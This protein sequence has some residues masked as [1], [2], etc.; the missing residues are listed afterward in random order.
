L[1]AI[2]GLQAVPLPGA[3]Q[4]A[5]NGELR[6][7]WAEAL[8]LVGTPDAW[9]PLTLE[10]AATRREVLKWLL[11]AAVW[12]VAVRLGQRRGT[13][14]ATQFVFGLGVVLGLTTWA[15]W[16]LGATQVFGVYQPV[17]ATGR[18]P[19]P[20]LN[21]NNL[22]C[23]LNLAAFCG[24]GLVTSRRSTR[25]E[26][27]LGLV[28]T[29][30]LAAGSILSGSRAGAGGLA[31]GFLAYGVVTLYR[32]RSVRF[33]LSVAWPSVAVVGLGLALAGLAMTRRA[34]NELQDASLVKFLPMDWALR[35]IWD[36]PFTG[37]GRGAFGAAVGPYRDQ[38]GAHTV[39]E[40]P[41]NWVLEWISGWGIPVGLLAVGTLLGA[42]APRRLL[43]GSWRSRLPLYIGCVVFVCQ[44]LVDL[45]S[46]VPG[47][48][49]PWLLLFGVLWGSRSARGAASAAKARVVGHQVW[50]LW[51]FCGL[52]LVLSAWFAAMPLALA[53]DERRQ[54]SSR[55][56][57]PQLYERAR[58]AVRAHPGDPYLL[59]V[60]ALSAHQARSPLALKWVNAALRRDPNN[61]RTL[62][63]LAQILQER[64]AVG[65]ALVS[66][67][68]AASQEQALA[69]TVAQIV[70]GWAPEQAMKAVPD[71]PLGEAML[72]QLANKA[73]GARARYE[74][75][76]ELLR[77]LPQSEL[78]A[79][80]KASVL[81]EASLQKDPL[82]QEVR[83]VS[84]ARDAIEPFVMSSASSQA[85]LQARA[86]VL[87]ASGEFKT[88]YALLLSGCPR[89]PSAARC[90]ELLL[91]SAADLP[92]AEYLVA[93][94]A[95]L[96]AMCRSPRGCQQAE[97][98]MSL[99]YERRGFTMAA[100][101]I[102]RSLV[103]RSPT[104][105]GWLRVSMLAEKAGRLHEA[106]VAIDRAGKLHSAGGTAAP[107]P[108]IEERKRLLNRAPE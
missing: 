61:S 62:V 29:A 90:H 89:S 108:R 52:L 45:G 105:D 32:E 13:R 72:A 78:G 17:F 18:V 75:A 46:E 24:L 91:R 31:L 47:V 19:S 102:T 10:P 28:G 70:L 74:F 66:L 57:E 48:V 76:S 71:G 51:G 54:L 23:V 99:A 53:R 103:R 96:D 63:L 21:P 41:E 4:A 83:C 56:A 85:V 106:V 58:S 38:M 77:R 12:G 73:S 84:L 67:R 34:A 20:L 49:L 30:V 59:R 44:N 92:Q 87:M 79:V 3:W 7:V 50:G 1:A 14:P 33:A 88:A 40:H 86:L 15:H 42:L 94:D 81:S 80:A 98:A 26:L 68:E 6:E 100:L 82:C 36:H 16:A 27:A 104:I 95:Y 60:A 39:F 107:D 64:G 37:V 11:Y 25:V 97:Q 8:A 9:H 2:T 43:A 93:G 55:L 22:S 35:M 65:Q 101:S 5:I 69:P